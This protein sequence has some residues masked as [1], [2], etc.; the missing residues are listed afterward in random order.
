[1]AWL[2]DHQEV[3]DLLGAGTGRAG[4]VP[5]GEEVAG[6]RYLSSHAQLPDV[7]LGQD[8]N[9]QLCW[10]AT[11]QSWAKTRLA[12]TSQAGRTWISWMS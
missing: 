6:L 11:E 1:M 10:A 9:R 3:Q 5:V 12:G 2:G 4:S 8:N 7:L